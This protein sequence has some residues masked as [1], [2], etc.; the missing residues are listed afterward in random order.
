MAV[1]SFAAA[2]LVTIGLVLLC[3]LSLYGLPLAYSDA[4]TDRTVLR[5]AAFYA[6]VLASTPFW[7]IGIWTTATAF[8]VGARPVVRWL[9]VGCCTVA[10]AVFTLFFCLG[11][12]L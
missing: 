2:V 5:E 8:A 12:D 10:A 6:A 3:S 7:L 9:G 1:G 11:P 4:R